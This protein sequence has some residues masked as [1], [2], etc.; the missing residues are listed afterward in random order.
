MGEDSVKGRRGCEMIEKERVDLVDG[1]K[2]VEV[3]KDC[4]QI[5]GQY[6]QTQH[7]LVY[8][9]E[10]GL[11]FAEISED[12]LTDEFLMGTVEGLLDEVG[13][14]GLAVFGLLHGLFHHNDSG[15]FLH[16]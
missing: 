2:V 8:V 1:D 16:F 13:F 15:L 6:E 5:V 14:V 3:G 4:G 11:Q 7:L 12:F 9:S 10:I